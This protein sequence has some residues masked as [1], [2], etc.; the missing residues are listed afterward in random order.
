MSE[1]LFTIRVCNDE[2][3]VIEDINPAC[4]RL[5][6]FPAAALVGKEPHECLPR[7]IADQIVSQY[8]DC[9]RSGHAMT[10]DRAF[11]L[12]GERRYWR[13][14]IAPV[15]DPSSGRIALLFGSTLDVTEERKAKADLERVNKRLISILASV[16]NS[17]CTFDRDLRLTAANAAAQEWMNLDERA[18]YG[19]SIWKIFSPAAAC[20][21][22]TQRA[23]TENRAFH[24]EL[25]SV[26]K[27]GRSIDF[28]VYPS[29]DGASVFFRDITDRKA[30]EQMA[31]DARGLLRSALNAL[32]ARI[33]ILDE[34][35]TVIA[36][37]RAWDRFAS[38]DNQADT[39]SGLG[40]RFCRALPCLD[41]AAR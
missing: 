1:S 19:T 22:A 13:T 36:T 17:Y 41:R 37:N 11:D 35:G 32:S 23:V 8:R 18:A 14:S 28:H 30:A 10:F 26:L 9:V 40:R 12:G 3:F 38:E 7:S 6:G 16:S 39:P 15:R 25:P 33:A 21:L 34:T 2:R 5:T 24:A 4:E 31:E 20:A 27:S 29:P